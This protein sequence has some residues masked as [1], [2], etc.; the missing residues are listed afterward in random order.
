MNTDTRITIRK[1]CK[2][3][4]IVTALACTAASCVTGKSLRSEPR[5]GFADPELMTSFGIC[6]LVAEHYI[7]K[8][9]WPLSKA[10]LE[11]Q[12]RKMLPQEDTSEFFGQFTLLEFK[13]KDDN[14]IL[15]YRFRIDKKAVDQT[16]TLKPKPTADA[17]LQSM[18]G[19]RE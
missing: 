16:V 12:A 17:I 1:V 4:S 9:E 14:L 13:K 5:C 2:F 6:D 7:A 8:H 19:G 3:A 18:S 10:Q 11:E 15:H